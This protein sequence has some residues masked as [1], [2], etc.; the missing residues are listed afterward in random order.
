MLEIILKRKLKIITY[1]AQMKI[2]LQENKERNIYLPFLKL[3]SEFNGILSA[4]VINERLFFCPADN[5][6]GKRMISYL[7]EGQHIAHEDEFYLDVI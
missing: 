1:E 2:G 4:K 5:I 6:R 7:A 3:A